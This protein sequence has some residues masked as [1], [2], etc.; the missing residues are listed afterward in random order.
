MRIVLAIILSIAFST[1]SL[2]VPR[3]G[4]DPYWKPCDGAN[5]KIDGTDCA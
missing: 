2:A 5:W 4:D 1:A 3:Q